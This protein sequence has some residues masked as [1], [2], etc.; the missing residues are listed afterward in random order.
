M[1]ERRWTGELEI[2]HDPALERQTVDLQLI[3]WAIMGLVV[4]A[5]LLGLFGNGPLSSATV[6]SSGSPLRVEYDRFLRHQ[7]PQRLRLHVEPGVSE[8]DEVR[9]WVSSSFLDNVQIER[10]EPRPERVEA[11]SDGQT[12]TFLVAGRGETPT[13]EIRFV[14]E[15]V[16]RLAIRMRIPGRRGVAFTQFVYP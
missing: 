16:G 10:I 2:A 8:S 7:A 4:L 13:I 15:R 9:V 6:G 1:A 5:A 14:P 12:F 3:G 11:G